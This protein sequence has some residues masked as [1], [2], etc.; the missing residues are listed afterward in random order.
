MLIRQVFFRMINKKV[1]AGFEAVLMVVSFFAL[2]YFAG[3]DEVGFVSA[4]EEGV[5]EGVEEEVSVVDDFSDW[6]GDISGSELT[7]NSSWNSYPISTSAVGM[8]CCF[9]NID[10]QPCGVSAPENCISDSPFAEGRLCAET[11]FCGKGC[12]YDDA[13]GVYDKNVLEVSCEADWI[14]DPNC[15]LPRA[16]LGCCILGSD[17]I[18]ETEGQCGVDSSA[19]GF[20]SDGVVDW[21]R[22]VGEVEC[23]LLSE[24]QEE[25]ACVFVGGG[26][27]FESEA[28]CL[29]N[30]GDFYADTLCTS[31]SLD[32]NCE[33]TRQTRCV[34]GEDEVFFVDTCGNLANVYDSARVDDESYWNEIVPYEDLCGADEGNGGSDD[35]GNCNRFLGGACTSA[36]DGDAEIGGF[37]C[38][39]LGCKFKGKEYES[40][41]SW[42]IYDGAIGDG[43][44]VVGSRH[45]KAVCSQ[46]Q[47]Q[48]EPCSDY[49]NQ[50]CIQSDGFEFEGEDIEFN[51][52]ACV[53]N[54]WRECIKLNGDEDLIKECGETL[55]CRVDTIDIADEFKFDVCLPKY[56]AGFDPSEELSA[57]SGE[58]VCGMGD[59]T[60]TVVRE[61]KFL[62]GCKYVANE[63]CLNED[64]GQQMNDL[65]RGLG[66]CGG[67]V[68][69]EGEW[70]DSYKITKTIE[71][72]SPKSRYL[73]SGWI[74]DLKDLANPV[75]G[76]FAE[77]EDYSEYL[78]DINI[79]SEVTEDE[80]DEDSVTGVNVAAGLAGLGYVAG[81]IATK[82]FSLAGLSTLASG[83]QTVGV[84]SSSGSLAA[85]TAAFSGVAIGAG[86][87]MIVG[88]MIAKSMGLSEGGSILM[89]TGG[90]LVGG[91]LTYSY[92]TS[93]ALL[94]GPVGWFG[95]GVMVVATIFGGSDCDPI[96]VQ[97][98]CEMWSPPVGGDDCD[99][100]N[101][102][103]LKSCS[104]YRCESL[105]AGCVMLNL[106]T[107]D[108]VCVDGNPYDVTPP[109][110]TH[111]KSPNYEKTNDGVRIVG[112][113]GGC[114][115][116]NT[117]LTFGVITNEPARC[118]FDVD[119]ATEYDDMIY[120][121]GRDSYLYN[122]SVEFL[123]PDPSHGQSQGWDW[124]GELEF[125]VKCMDRNGLVSPGAY[126]I[127]MC[128]AEG[129]DVLG[130]VI[131]DSST[132]DML[133]GTDTVNQDIRIFTNELAS[134]RW[135]L[136]DV[137]YSDMGNELE[138]GD[139]LGNPSNP[140]GYFCN[141][142]VSVG[143]NT[144][145]YYVRCVDQPW[146]DASEANEGSYSFEL[147]KPSSRISIDKIKPDSDYQTSTDLT[148]VDLRIA[149]SG[150]GDAHFCSYSL[151]GYDQM[152]DILE[153]GTSK[154]H[155]VNLNMASGKQKVYVEC[156]DETGDFARDMTEF[157]ISRDSSSPTIAR[158]W[159]DG[160]A[161]NI[162]TTEESEC[163][164]SVETCR[165]AWSE[166]VSAGEGVEHR[167]SVDRGETYYVKCSD[168]FGNMPNGCSVEVVAV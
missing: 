120:D 110:V 141:G 109:L 24:T 135:N 1:V 113:G 39:D 3:F 32:T 25:G 2:G 121:F 84:L 69:Y 14:A 34:N 93:G 33:P 165:F 49:R 31:D 22:D 111:P 116:A 140:N 67:S 145:A 80:E 20:S 66:D 19:R 26:C 115:S 102:D 21:N 134:C 146:L 35:C 60:C 133:V 117:F 46:G 129:E 104:P 70:S 143:E 42:C 37:Y 75:F 148:T 100:C 137:N 85:S 151:S 138:C 105:G 50:I 78:E 95:L 122:H 123:L 83:T 132:G 126:E 92:V 160:G 65:C 12:C 38:E 28:E 101:G 23:L 57:L 52:A 154:T 161:L 56:P 82:S 153:T 9:V 152:F 86:I 59:V 30:G 89:A 54:N 108:E 159:Q 13:S 90:A 94:L 156:R 4:E 142:D 127:S 18:F 98:E 77:V 131:L 144:T 87:G 167:I 71:G 155:S 6:L 41:E 5:E 61:P 74:S 125:F 149:T 11:S 53:V 15:N 124:S 76:Q 162:V 114:L 128:V 136:D 68:N 7:V 164:Y 58:S 96:E 48:I 72:G 119:P 16:N 44:D 47:A 166:G 168:D 147:R 157:E 106:G 107:D 163:R 51:N 139:R 27:K 88:G 130:P 158:I 91:A 29:S 81:A 8:G 112:S 99:K 73:S 17:T 79:F 40:G 36:G 10:G 150:G 103:L 55:N 45:W 63:D 118:A 97:F 62:G 43:D 64:F